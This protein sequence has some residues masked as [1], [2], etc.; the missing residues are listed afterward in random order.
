MNTPIN[1]LL[2]QKG[3]DIITIAPTATVY[4]AIALMDEKNIGSLLVLNAHGKIAGIFAERDAFRKV[5]LA[6]KDPKE[7]QVRA[8]MTKKV[9]YVAPESTVDECMALM[10]D[11]RIR[12]I[13]VLDTDQKVLGI[14][15][16]GDLVKFVASEQDALIKNL[17]RYIEGS[18]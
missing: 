7:V 8:A 9:V 6:G 14:I 2:M 13:P 12:H 1:Q 17:E 16:I 18:L 3:R 11:K 5:I 10:T 4:E 15:S